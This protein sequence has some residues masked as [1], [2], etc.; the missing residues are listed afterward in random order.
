MVVAHF[1]QSLAAMAIGYIL[2]HFVGKHDL[3]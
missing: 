2:G 1:I 3:D